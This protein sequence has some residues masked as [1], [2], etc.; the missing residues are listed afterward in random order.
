[1][2]SDGT[3]IYAFGGNTIGGAQHAEANKYNPTTNTWT[4]LASMT[5]GADYLFHADYGNN[6][7]IYVMGGLNVGTLNRIYDIA[8]NSYSAGA[9]VPVAVYDQGHAYWNG[10]VYVIGGI[11]G[12]I[13]SNT[14]YAYD[15]ATNTWSAPLAPL[16]QAEFNMAC[17][18]INNKIYC[19]NGSTGSNQI[20]NL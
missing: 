12:G 19:A 5:T 1:M 17:G 3:S 14:V 2:A 7:K 9:P 6:G 13:A 8:T 16:P 18:A 11:V 15:V 4:P 10:K 20:N